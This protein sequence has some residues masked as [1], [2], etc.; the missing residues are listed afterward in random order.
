MAEIEISV[1]VSLCLDRRID[2]IETVR[3]EVA[4][5]QA[6]RDNLQVIA[7]DAPLGPEW[8]HHALKGE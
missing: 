7:N 4:A 2:S 5:W 1:M 3:S 8:L 6:H